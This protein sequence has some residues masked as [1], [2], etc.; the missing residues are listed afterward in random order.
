MFHVV[1]RAAGS[2][3]NGVWIVPR[4][5]PL[6][7]AVQTADLRD[8]SDFAS[9][10]KADGS[11]VTVA[12][13]VGSQVAVTEARIRRFHRAEPGTTGD[14]RAYSAEPSFGFEFVVE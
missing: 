5:L 14:Q 6:E 3:A 7:I 9:L 13:A 2:N 8:L 11:A 4:S 10:V 12:P 1:I